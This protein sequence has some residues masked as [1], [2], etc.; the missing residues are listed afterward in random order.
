M[1]IRV[2]A[3]THTVSSAHAYSTL[4]ENAR[5]AGEAGLEALGMT[6]HAQPMADAPLAVHFRNLR[7]IDR[8]L[9]GVKILRGVELNIC[10]AQGSVFLPERVLEGLDY[11]IASIHPPIYVGRA[12]Q[13]NTQAYIRA[14]QNPYVKI[15]GHPEDGHVPVEFESLVQAARDTHTMLE[16]NN[17]S[18]RPVTSRI[19]TRENMIRMLRLCE[20]YGVYVST[21]TDAHFANAVGEFRET[22]ALLEEIG[23]PEELVA[24]TS[25]EKFLSLIKRKN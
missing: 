8:E 19:H 1:I 7:V 14:M 10:D 18:L 13:E 21:G 11:C 2:D 12:A 5:H 15:L 6:D 23:F 16:V 22:I 3:H 20:R 17:T 25:C 9:F 4:L 24:G